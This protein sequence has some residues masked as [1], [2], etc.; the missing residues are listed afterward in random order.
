MLIK[1]NSSTAPATRPLLGTALLALVLAGCGGGSDGG[2]TSDAGAS[3]AGAIT[4]KTVANGAHQDTSSASGA[5]D[6]GHA[7]AGAD[8]QNAAQNGGNAAPADGSAGAAAQPASGATPITEAGIS[9][10]LF[11]QILSTQTAYVKLGQRDIPIMYGYRAAELESTNDG[12]RPPTLDK[13]KE[14]GAAD[15]VSYQQP[16]DGKFVVESWGLDRNRDKEKPEGEHVSARAFFGYAFPKAGDA[17]GGRVTLTSE[18]ELKYGYQQAQGGGTEYRETLPLKA[19]ADKVIPRDGV[20]AFNEPVQTWRD[21]GGPLPQMTFG[22]LLELRIE[23]G[24]AADEVLFCLEQ[25]SRS[26]PQSV[27]TSGNPGGPTRADVQRKVCSEWQV[28]ATWKPQQNLIYRG[29]YVMDDLA[30]DDSGNPELIHFYHTKPERSGRAA[31]ASDAAAAGNAGAAAQPAGQAS[32]SAEASADVTASITQPPADATAVASA[33]AQAD[34][35]GNGA[36]SVDTSSGAA[37]IAA[38]QN[39]GA[40]GDAAQA[41]AAAGNAAQNGA[42]AGAAAQPAASGDAAAQPAPAAKP[43]AAAPAADGAAHAADTSAAAASGSQHAAGDTHVATGHDAGSQHGAD[44][45][46]HDADSGKHGADSDKHEGDGDRHGASGDSHN[47]SGDK[48]DVGDKHDDGDD[49]DEDRDDET[50]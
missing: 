2:G 43:D 24:D 1:A 26:L 3:D 20:I 31:S 18:A 14:S 35:R 32:A 50:T 15:F 30:T 8:G 10:E 17:A 34:S 4:P 11:A 6:S 48:H 28:P 42:A 19:D 9:T 23:K 44:S 37:A 27:D 45:G 12:Q 22:G 21:A 13:W 5:A 36:L 25:R 47:A 39:G 40:A 46:K 41:G 16:V 38:Q 7:A 49:D 29:I 33:A